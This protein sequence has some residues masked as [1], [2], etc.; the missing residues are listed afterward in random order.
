MN[1][2]MLREYFSKELRWGWHRQYESQAVF[3]FLINAAEL[4]KNGVIRMLAPGGKD[5]NH[6]SKTAFT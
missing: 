1:K 4:Y 2:S 6:F 5:M 3:A